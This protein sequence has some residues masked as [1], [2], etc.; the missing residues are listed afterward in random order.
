MK[1]KYRKK[2]NEP[3]LVDLSERRKQARMN[4]INKL[5]MQTEEDLESY[6]LKLVKNTV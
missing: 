2:A 6:Q 5:K 4:K 3:R 1:L